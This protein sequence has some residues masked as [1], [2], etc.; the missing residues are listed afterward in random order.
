MMSPSEFPAIVKLMDDGVQKE[1]DLEVE[2][3]NTRTELTRYPLSPSQIGKCALALARNLAHFEGIADYPRSKDSLAPRTKRIFARGDLLEDALIADIERVTPLKVL[4]RQKLVTL[5]HVKHPVTQVEKPITGNIDGIAVSPKG[6]RVL[7]DFKSKGAFYSAA[8]SDSISQ[9]F[10]E[11]RATG[12][13]TEIH[14]NCFLITDAKALFDIMSM[15]EFFIDYLLQLNSYA[16]GLPQ[17]E[18]VDFVALY[19]ENKNTCANYEVRWEPKQ[20]LL[21]YAKE[22]F[23]Y[24][25]D[26]VHTKGPEAVDKEFSLGSSR[27]RLCDHNERCWGKYEP[28]P[29]TDRVVGQLGEQLE[30]ALRAAQRE[31]HVV[32]KVEEA[33]LQE[34][35]TKDLTHIQTSDGLIYERKFLKSPKPHYELRLSK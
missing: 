22:K 9:F 18:K 15:D 27:C 7:L 19:Y 3:W 21:D 32:A 10:M 29:R 28:R 6:V 16:C 33:V 13:V 35:Q 5:F 4:E 8:F 25:Y 20:E 14:P 26:T 17:D 34:M 30:N 24:I 2:Q 31:H 11:L 1:I 23:Q 12:L